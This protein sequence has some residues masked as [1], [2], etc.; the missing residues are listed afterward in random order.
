VARKVRGNFP[1]LFKRYFN[2]N[3][4]AAARDV[5]GAMGNLA[6]GMQ[7]SPNGKYLLPWIRSAT[8]SS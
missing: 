2:F 8:A 4:P 7:T 3:G 6:F 5:I 1:V